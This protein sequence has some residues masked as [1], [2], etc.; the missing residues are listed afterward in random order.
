MKSNILDDLN[1]LEDTTFEMI[2]DRVRN[3]EDVSLLKKIYLKIQECKNIYI[4]DE[5]SLI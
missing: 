4:L 5:I 3:N 2:A 1:E